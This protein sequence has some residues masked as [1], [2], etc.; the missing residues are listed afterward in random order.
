MPNANEVVHHCEC[1]YVFSMFNA[2]RG[3]R[4]LWKRVPKKCY[5]C[6]KPWPLGTPEEFRWKYFSDEAST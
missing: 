5:K 4:E 2:N 6:H 1:G 3:S